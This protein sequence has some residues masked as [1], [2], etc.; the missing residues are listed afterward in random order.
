MITHIPEDIKLELVDGVLTLKAGSKVYVPNGFEKVTKYYKDVVT[1]KYWKE[2][3]TEGEPELEYA[4][5][6]AD[7]G[8]TYY[9]L[10]APIGS[11]MTPYH[12]ANTGELASSSSELNASSPYSFKTVSEEK[13]TQVISGIG[14]FT[15]TRYRDGDLYIDT[16]TTTVVEGTP[17]DYTYTTTETE[18]IEVGADDDWTRFEEIDTD[19]KKFDVV[20]AVTDINYSGS[21]KDDTILMDV[22]Y[23]TSTFE[24]TAILGNKLTLH[25][26]GDTPPS[27]GLF[28]NITDNT[29]K[30]YIDG[31]VNRYGSFPIAII[32]RSSTSQGSGYVKSLDQVFN[33][34]GYIGSTVYALPGVRGL[35]PNGFNADGSLNSIEFAVDSVLTRT[36]SS[37]TGTYVLRIHDGDAIYATSSVVYKPEENLIYVQGSVYTSVIV[38]EVVYSS[39][40]V[41][42]LTPKKVGEG[43]I[44]N[45]L[46]NITIKKRFYYKYGTEPNATIVGSPTINNG[47]VSGFS[48]SNYCKTPSSPPSNISSYEWFCKFTVGSNVTNQQ[49]ILANLASN[50]D[51]PQLFISTDGTIQFLHPIS[52]SAWSSAL[53]A[54]LTPNTT[55]WTKATWDG[56]I[57]SFYYK[58]SESSDYI[59]AGTTSATTINWTANVGIGINTTTYPFYGSIDL[60]ESYIKINNK[61]W[62]HGTKVVESDKNDYDYYIDKLLSY[63]PIV[64]GK[65]SYYKQDLNQ[66]DTGTYTFT[67]DKDYTARM[68]FVGNGG[69]GCTSQKDSRWHYSSGGSGAVFEGLVRFPADTYTL[70]IGSLGYGNNANNTHYHSSSVVSTDSFLTNSAGEELI[71]VGAGGN[72]Y[73]SVGGVGGAAGVLTLGTLDIIETKKA[74]DGVYTAG[75]VSA[76][77]VSAYDG[78]YSGYGAGTCGQRYQGNVYGIA[79]IFDLVLETDIT[80]YDWYEDVGT[81][82]Y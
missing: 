51:T 8:N 65:R 49:G 61:D 45:K 57:V 27:L 12:I 11:D 62:W 75:N 19:I 35:I 38:G 1:T 22:S 74:T 2:I 44:K 69:G 29:T 16:T 14:T 78:T 32:T 30:L 4:C 26:S 50:R 37:S 25:F 47:V 56:S 43:V 82:V 68:L 46:Y 5:Y 67:L 76:G 23:N 52:S 6:K 41:T 13:C 73:T 10:K 7:G 80:D 17:E 77:T 9:Y 40:I 3:T 53:S 66:R 59:L 79:G 55:Y 24:I 21:A 34:F 48:A 60:T 15:Y 63:A 18:T 36:Y 33:G 58:T 28:Y 64:R 81:K 71:R 20:T 42:S 31:S 72:G 39:G 54:P 70:T